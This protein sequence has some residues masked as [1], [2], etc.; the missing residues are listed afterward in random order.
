MVQRTTTASPP[1]WKW[2]VAR[3]RKGVRRPGGNIR[4]NAPPQGTPITVPKRIEAEHIVFMR[5]SANLAIKIA[6]ASLGRDLERVISEGVRQ[7][8]RDGA[9]PLAHPWER[10]DVS[11]RFQPIQSIRAIVDQMR[12]AYRAQFDLDA[13]IDEVAE[14]QGKIDRANARRWSLNTVTQIEQDPAVPIAV[15]VAIVASRPQMK[16]RNIRK[17][18]RRNVNAVVMPVRRGADRIFGR[19]SK[20]IPEEFF[21]R[22]ESTLTQGARQTAKDIGATAPFDL[23]VEFELRT[24]EAA[25]ALEANARRTREELAKQPG[26]TRR[27]AKAIGRD[28]TEKL[29]GD[30]TEDRNEAVGVEDYRWNTQEDSKVRPEHKER[31]GKI[32]KWSR[33]PSD[34]H[35]GEPAEC[36]CW[37]SGDFRKAFQAKTLTVRTQQPT[38]LRRSRRGPI[39]PEELP[40]GVDPGQIAFQREVFEAPRRPSQIARE[41]RDRRLGAGG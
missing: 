16:L 15:A 10:F 17:W 28:Q 19:K 21:D 2:F 24:P 39:R 34:G 31:E 26:I 13:A 9:R 23:T 11:K 25:Q 40:A 4:R 41:E 36:R 30:A 29:N 37:A 32:F 18:V 38:P 33:P 1:S 5:R 8:R 35:P 7:V 22:I 3:A 12:D 27:R 14:M 20:T 6:A